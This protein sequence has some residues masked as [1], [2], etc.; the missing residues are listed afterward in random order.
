MLLKIPQG[1]RQLPQDS[2]PTKNVS[3]AEVEKAGPCDCQVGDRWS[4]SIRKL[5]KLGDLYNP[6]QC[7]DSTIWLFQLRVKSTLPIACRANSWSKGLI[8]AR[9]LEPLACTASQSLPLLL[10]KVLGNQHAIFLFS[11]SFLYS[12]H[13]SVEEPNLNGNTHKF[14]R[15]EETMHLHK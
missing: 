13:S 2:Y 9:L 4:L 3:R 15:L 11:V 14:L 10:I 12:W 6:F 8:V 5:L 7:W 1:T